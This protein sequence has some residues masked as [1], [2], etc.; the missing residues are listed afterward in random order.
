MSK[1][2]NYFYFIITMYMFI[3]SYMFSNNRCPCL[4]DDSEFELQSRYYITFGRTNSFGKGMNSI[5]PPNNAL[6]VPQLLLYK[7]CIVIK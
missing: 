3:I 2:G 5:I 6:I 1:K 7:D 4:T